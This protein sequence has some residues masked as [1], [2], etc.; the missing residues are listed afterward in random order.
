MEVKG[1]LLFIYY[2]DIKSKGK[3]IL[4]KFLNDNGIEQ[5]DA[6]TKNKIPVIIIGD[7]EDDDPT[8]CSADKM[9]S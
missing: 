2:K 4:K 1:E 6:V 9:V 5:G 3:K 7:L 8:K